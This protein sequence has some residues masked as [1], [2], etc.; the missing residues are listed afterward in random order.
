MNNENAGPFLDIPDQSNP[1]V[2]REIERNER[3]AKEATAVI[4]KRFRRRSGEAQIDG[5]LNVIGIM[6]A[7]MVRMG[8][9]V[10]PKMGSTFADGIR[11]HIQKAEENHK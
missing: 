8:Y 7:Q 1:L 5:M 9:Q 2:R 6:A 3:T 11:F 4:M 10:D